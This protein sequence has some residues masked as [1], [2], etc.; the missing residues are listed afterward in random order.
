MDKLHS[1]SLSKSIL[2]ATP[3]FV[4]ILA[5]LNSSDELSYLFVLN[6]LGNVAG[7]ADL[8]FMSAAQP[9]GK[10]DLEREFIM[11]VRNISAET[12]RFELPLVNISELEQWA[13]NNDNIVRGVAPRWLV[14]VKVAQFD[15]LV[16]ISNIAK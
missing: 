8:T 16:M 5:L 12:M 11:R 3:L 14:P 10:G 6:F 4:C 2:L 1:K 7:R 9:E 15:G 13:I